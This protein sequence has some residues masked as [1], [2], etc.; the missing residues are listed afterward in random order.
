MAISR[1]IFKDTLY[2]YLKLRKYSHG[3]TVVNMALGFTE[4][5]WVASSSSEATGRWTEPK[6]ISTRSAPGW[7]LVLLIL[8]VRCDQVNL[9][10]SHVLSFSSCKV[11]VGVPGCYLQYVSDKL[12]KNIGVAAQNCYKA[13]KGAFTGE[14]A[15]AMIKVWLINLYSPSTEF[16]G[17]LGCLKF[18]FYWIFA[19]WDF[20]EFSFCAVAIL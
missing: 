8:T 10:N 14:L 9:R 19:D 6:Q 12:P 20:V 15:P 3:Y 16:A 4:P 13:A 18:G 2:R 7:P 17:W 11:V 5:R 1:V